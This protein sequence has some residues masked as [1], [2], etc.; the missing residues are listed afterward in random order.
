M[1]AA[2]PDRW[3]RLPHAAIACVALGLVLRLAF[4]LLYWQ[5][6]PLTHDER[7]YLALAANLAAGRGFTTDLPHEPPHPLADRFDRAPLYPLFLAPLVALDPDLRE[8]RLPADVPVSVK[9]AQ[10]LVGAVT[11]WLIALLARRLAGNGA[12]TVSALIA[13]VYPPLVWMC[14]Y[15]LSEALAAALAMAAVL[16]LG[17]ALDRRGA[18]GEDAAPVK[19][20]LAGGALLGL[21]TLVRPA[22]LLAL[23]L[24]ALYLLARR[25]V[26]LAILLV[27]G[28]AVV[29]APWTLRN[30]REHGQVVLVSA[31][32]GVNFWI[33]NHPLAI[34]D[35]DLA[36]NPQL[37]RANLELR[38]RH[39]GLDAVGLEPVYYREALG[40]IGREPVRWLALMAR[41]AFYTVVPVGPSY[42]L[43]SALYFWAS[44]VPY[45]LLLPLAILGVRVTAVTGTPPVALGLLVASA[46][47]AS[48]V[49]FPHE[50]F[51][52]PV[53]DPA[54][55]V[56]AGSWIGTR[57]GWERRWR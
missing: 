11:V 50:R 3:W 53:I 18:P 56:L 41:K 52:M 54:L 37:K 49:F 40:W 51:R 13:A 27:V 4:G 7:E 38:A 28:A 1:E 16:A 32:G 19:Y 6:K 43:H 22:T 17:T 8:G 55:V 2:P 42:H 39:P 20:I 26:G 29:I 10:G 48:L 12:A 46:L 35:G 47:A 14:A 44:V 57:A 9:V 36:A 34:G 21:A 31:Q 45:A 24:V 23:P 15:A 30:V 25:R 5:G 33:G